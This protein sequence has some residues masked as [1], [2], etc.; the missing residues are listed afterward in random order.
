VRRLA[1]A[2]LA[3]LTFAGSAWALDTTGFRYERPLN[4]AEDGPISFT[5]DGRMYGHAQIGFS[6]LRII[7]G[8]G[9]QV[10]WRRLPRPR[11]PRPVDVRVLNAGRQGNAAVALLDLGPRRTLR[12]RLELD[13]PDTG[14]VGR[15]RVSGTDDRR[16]F[17]RLSTS[18]VYDI[19]G[20]EG[21]ARSTVVTFPPSDFR[22][23]QLKARGISE[24]AGATVSGRGVS[25]KALVLTGT[26]QV[27]STG[28]ATLILVDLEYP[29]VPVD[30]VRV[31]ARTT[32]YDRPATVSG[33]NDGKNW[34]PLASARV[35]RLPGS[36]ATVGS[37]TPGTSIRIDGR[38]RYLRL[39]IENGDDAPLEAIEVTTHA[40]PRPLLVEGGH[41]RPLRA[42][43][44]DPFAREP[45]YDFAR[46]PVPKSTAFAPGALGP[47]RSNELFEPPP[48]TRS[49]AA[50][51][52]SLITVALV[53]AALSAAA[54][55]GLALRRRA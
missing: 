17:T 21:R 55:G 27:E 32:Q 41:P 8:A 24:I 47:E 9:E 54:A 6:D 45:V 11:A 44:G 49:F 35:Y 29:K 14:F 4:A 50:R 5:P 48:D 51:H 30:E 13:I 7:D 16:T 1:V 15:V 25:P 38:H 23:L 46:L 10:P 39:R 42:F 20:A 31:S 19:E 26:A 43:Y 3:G 40:L 18:V 12:D 36:R 2:L 37:R 22:Y 28:R 33:S 53:I 34:V 52:S